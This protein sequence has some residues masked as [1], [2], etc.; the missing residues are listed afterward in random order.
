MRADHAHAPDRA[1]PLEHRTTTLRCQRDLGL[2]PFLHHLDPHPG[3][4]RKAGEDM[5]QETTLRQ[6]FGRAQAKPLVIG[7]GN[8]GH[9]QQSH[10]EP[11]H[12]GPGQP[13]AEGHQQ[14][15]TQA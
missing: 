14:A 9:E 5:L 11:Q 1:H 8:T 4:E 13:I 12:R 2:G 15:H 7:A 3:L 6:G 10:R